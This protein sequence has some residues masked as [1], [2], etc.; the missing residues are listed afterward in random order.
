[1]DIPSR[2]PA[3]QSSVPAL[4][5][6]YGSGPKAA[7]FEVALFE[8]RDV[9]LQCLYTCR[10][11]EHEHIEVKVLHLLLGRPLHRTVHHTLLVLEL[12]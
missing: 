10:P 3:G 8:S 6:P 1:M 11:E 7:I 4:D 12:C 9:L 5:S 2:V